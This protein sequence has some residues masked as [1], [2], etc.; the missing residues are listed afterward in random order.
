MIRL[1]GILIAISF[2]S[3][4]VSYFFIN[5]LFFYS[6]LI[7]WIA[8]S[9]LYFTLKKK[10]LINI[11]LILTFLNLLIANHYDFK[12]DI[13]KLFSVNQYLIVLL[14]GVGFLRLISSPKIE[15]NSKKQIGLKSFLKTYLGVHLF[16]SVINLSAFIIVADRLNKTSK[17][18]NSQLITLTRSFS[19]DAFWSPFFVSFA[20]AL[21][22]LPSFDKFTIFVNGIFLAIFTFLFTF[23][24]VKYR[25]DFKKFEGYPFS[26]QTLYIPFLLAI[27]VLLSKY[28]NEDLKVIVLVSLYAFLL[29]AIILILKTSFLNTLKELSTF[30]STDLPNI[31]MELSLFLIAGMFGISLSTL[32]NGFDIQ[33]PFEIFTY[34]EAIITLALF[35][36]LA[37]IGIHPIITIAVLGDL[38]S[39]FNQT[40]LVA[41]FLMSWS[42]TVASSPFSGLNLTIQG[43]YKLNPK[44]VF[45]LNLPYAIIMFLICSIFLYFLDRNFLN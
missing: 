23:I 1:S 7:I 37:F 15:E 27:L 43:R 42:I 21:T 20:A 12:I 14:I 3:S 16:G 39:G 38:M 34:K 41:T 4:L 17:L 29:T 31:K 45:V 8:F 9:I 13:V 19:S 25:F 36:I 10:R 22:Y 30:I 35:I 33:I 5:E 40:L 11:L 32:L 26:F 2:F 6:S 18:T 24:D 44:E 28:L